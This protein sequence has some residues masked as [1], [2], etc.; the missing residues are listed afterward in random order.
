MIK[1]E[2]FGTLPC[3]CEVYSYTLENNSIVSVSILNYGGII[4]NIFVKDK[5]GVAADVI[6]GFDVLEGYLTSGGYQGALIGRIGNRIG[7][8]K[9]TLDG[10]EYTL[11][12]NDGN[13][14]LHGGQYGFNAKIWDVV[15]CG[16]DDEPSLVLTYVSPDGEE[17]Y[18]GVLTV[19]VTY[20]LTAEGGVSI[21]YEA[22]TDKTTIVNLTNHAYFNLGGLDAGVIDDHVLWMDCDRINSVDSELIPD[23]KLIDVTGTPYDFRNS[24]RVGDGFGSD[25]PMLSACGGYDH[26]FCFANA[27]GSIKLRVTAKDPKSGRELKMYTDQPCV[28]LYTGN[29][30]NVNDHVFKNNIAQYTHCAFCLETQAMPDSINHE[31]FTNVILRPGE[32]YDTTTVYVFGN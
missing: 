20:T 19:K 3:G 14:S 16:T 8:A 26:N 27:D 17:G 31:G 7:K 13:N 1:K 5:N 23:G 11:Y 9:F 15:E 21:H 32:K 4:K 30:I 25:E 18:P 2:L 24:H 22:E 6:G 29:M 12:K 28:Q 10:K